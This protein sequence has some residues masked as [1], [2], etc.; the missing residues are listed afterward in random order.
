MGLPHGRLEVPGAATTAITSGDHRTYEMVRSTRNG[1][2]WSRSLTGRSIDLYGVI[3]TMRDG[4]DSPTNLSE[5]QTW[6]I[7]VF[8]AA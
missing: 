1:P 3:S 7:I 6:Y 8:N 5:P 2:Q 4:S